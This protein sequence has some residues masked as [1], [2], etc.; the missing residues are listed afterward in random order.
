M[1]ARKIT[2]AAV[3]PTYNYAHFLTFA[4]DSILRQTRPA[5]EIIVVDDGSTDN[6]REV[7]AGYGDRVRY[8]YQ[9]NAGLS[10]ARNTGTREASSD[11]VAY[12]DSDDAW[13]PA[14]LQLQEQNLSQLPDALLSYTGK[15]HIDV[16]GTPVQSVPAPPPDALWPLMRACNLLPASSVMARRDAVLRAGGFNEELRACEDWDMWVRLRLDGPI[17]GLAEPLT[18]VRLTP[19]SMS[20]NVQ[21]MIDNMERIREGTL[22]KGLTGLSRDLWTRRIRSVQMFHAAVTAQEFDRAEGRKYLLNSLANWPFWSPERYY[23]L[24]L[25]LLGAS[26]RRQISALVRL[27]KE[28][29]RR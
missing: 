1:S 4:V 20:T 17:T 29:G 18:L 9:P 5:D 21:R 25:N 27:V 11:W 10:A 22:L 28:T 14:K 8:V 23:A 19:A 13:D 16:S 15:I 3:V 26:A 2:I 12:L 7:I 24:L 6:T